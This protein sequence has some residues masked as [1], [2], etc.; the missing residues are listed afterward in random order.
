MLQGAA[1]IVVANDNGDSVEV[2]EIGPGEC[3]GDHVTTGAGTA[4]MGIVATKDV[5][6]MVFDSTE[7]HELL[8]RSPGLASEIGDAIEARRLASKVVKSRKVASR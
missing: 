5:K 6:I 3:F 8:N 7:I 1:R 2:G 4:D